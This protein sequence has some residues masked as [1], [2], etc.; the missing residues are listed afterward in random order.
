MLVHIPNMS[1]YYRQ[2]YEIFKASLESMIKHADYPHTV[3][4][5]DNA[6]CTAVA[7]EINELQRQGVIDVVIRTKHN[8][9][10]YWGMRWIFWASPGKVV[11]YSD[12]DMFFFPGWLKESMN[13]LETYPDVGCVSAY[14]FRPQGQ[15]RDKLNTATI[16]WAEANATVWEARHIPPDWDKQSCESVGR[17]WEAYQEETKDLKELIVEYK[18]VKAMIQGHHCQFIGYKNI[19]ATLPAVPTAQ[20]MGQL[21]NFDHLMNSR[22]FL[23]LNT[24]AGRA[25]HMG[26][27]IDPT[28]FALMRQFGIKGDIGILYRPPLGSWLVLKIKPLRWLLEHL[29]EWLYWSLSRT[30]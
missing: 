3:L 28:M 11:A 19:L 14:P 23:R 16:E 12:D 8:V 30:I 9:G 29:Y 17:D 7:E 1:G 20:L 21:L 2:R 13:V 4:V 6:S 15:V 10:K 22:G 24:Y 5:F 25:M 27:V 26:N 18:D